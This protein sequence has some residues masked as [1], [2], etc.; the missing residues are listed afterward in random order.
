MSRLSKWFKRGNT[1]DPKRPSQA[2]TPDAT[3]ENAFSQAPLLE[4][5][6]EQLMHSRMILEEQAPGQDER[7]NREVD[8]EVRSAAELSLKRLHVIQ[9]G[10]CP[11][12]GDTLRQHLFASICDSCGWH[13]FDTPRNGP[14]RVHLHNGAH[15]IE[16]QRCYV[17]KTGTVLVLRDD[18]VIARVPASAVSWVE[19]VWHSGELDQ[20]HRSALERLHI[21]CGWCNGPV[22]PDADGFHMVQAA[23]GSTQER[24]CFCCDDCYEAFRKMYPARVHRN[25]YE[26][27]CAECNLCTKRY[28]DETEGVRT[29]AKDLLRPIRKL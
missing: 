7:L 4:D 11:S 25:C 19:Y 9:R 6:H 26:R 2:S 29:L 24:Y 22:D 23:F 20:R 3:P 8:K 14:A 15:P 5:Q 18:V 12:C 13:H 1:A 27:S 17:V 10:H 28:E 16:G 21:Q